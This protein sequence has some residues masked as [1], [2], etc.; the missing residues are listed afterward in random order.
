MPTLH[1]KFQLIH[2]LGHKKYRLSAAPVFFPRKRIGF[3]AF[4]V[5]AG[6]N[7]LVFLLQAYF[8]KCQAG[9]C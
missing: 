7:Q 3:A 8:C 6:V 1:L 9:T 2:L 4:L 5:S